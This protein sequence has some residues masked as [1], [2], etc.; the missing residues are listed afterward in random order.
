MENLFTFYT[1][2]PVAMKYFEGVSCEMLLVFCQTI[3]Y[4][5]FE[6]CAYFPIAPVLQAAELSVSDFS[7]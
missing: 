3:T 6:L 7:S 4:L 5:P 2:L 1:F